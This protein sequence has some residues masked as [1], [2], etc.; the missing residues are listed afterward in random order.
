MTTK[1]KYELIDKTKVS[2]KVLEILE[3]ME[4]ASSNFTNAEVNSRVDTA[5]D[6]I[7]EGLKVSKPEALLSV[8]DAKKEVKKEKKEAE[9]KNKGKDLSKKKDTDDKTGLPKKDTVEERKDIIKKESE[10]E[11]EARERAKKEL[12]KENEKAKDAIESQIEK[13]NRIILEDPALRG[14]NTGTSATGGGKSTPLIDAERKAIA[15]GRRVSQKGR[16][17]QY[18]AS[19]GGRVYW[20]NRENRS[21]RK[22]PDYPT[23]KPYLEKGGYM[24]K[25]GSV[26]ESGYYAYPSG[27]EGNELGV[28]KD[29]ESMIS[30]ALANKDKYGKLIF[31]GI[32]NDDILEVNKRDSQDVV[33]WVFSR[34]G[35]DRKEA[36]KK[37]KMWF[38]SNYPADEEEAKQI[39]E[40]VTFDDI[41]FDLKNQRGIYDRLGNSYVVR[42][43]FEKIASIYGVEYD[44]VEK[45]YKRESYAKGGYMADGGKVDKRILEKVYESYDIYKD[46]TNREHYY[47]FDNI[48]K[49]KEHIEKRTGMEVL[50]IKEIE[51]GRNYPDNMSHPYYHDDYEFELVKGQ[52]LRVER[53]YGRPNYSGNVAYTNTIE[54]KNLWQMADGGRVNTI[55]LEREI[56]E[57]ENKYPKA[58]VSYS[59]AKDS[60]GKGYVIRAKEG[61]KIVYS[62]YKAKYGGMMADGGQIDEDTLQE[63]S[64][65][66]MDSIKPDNKLSLDEFLYAHRNGEKRFMTDEQEKL[67]VFVVKMYDNDENITED[68]LHELARLVMNS[69]NPNVNLSLDE[70][71]VEI[72]K[73]T[74]QDELCGFVLGMFPEYREYAKGGMMADGGYIESGE[75][76]Y[77]IANNMSDKEFQEAYRNL[78]EKEKDL[79]DTLLRLGDEGKIALVTVLNESKKPKYDKSTWDL[80]RYA[81]GGLVE[82]IKMFDKY[83]YPTPKTKGDKVRAIFEHFKKK[84]YST[85]QINTALSEINYAKGGEMANGGE[86]NKSGKV[87][88]YS[89][90]ELMEKFNI[91]RKQYL[92]YADWRAELISK[93]SKEGYQEKTNKRG[94]WTKKLAEGG[95]TESEPLG[96][97]ESVYFEVYDGNRNNG[98]I[99]FHKSG[100]RIF[101]T[102]LIG[103]VKAGNRR[104]MSYFT[105]NDLKSSLY[106]DFDVVNEVDEDY[107]QD[108]LISYEKSKPAD[109]LVVKY[110]YPE[111][112]KTADTLTI[113]KGGEQVFDYDPITKDF[114]LVSIGLSYPDQIELDD[115]LEDSKG[116]SES[117]YT[118]ELIK[119][120]EVIKENEDINEIVDGLKSKG[121]IKNYMMAE[122]GEVDFSERMAKMRSAY[123][124]LQMSVKGKIASAIGIDEA[125]AIMDT[126]YSIHPFNLIFG[127]VRGGLLELDEINK[128]LVNEAVDE[129]ERVTD[130]YRDSGQGIGGSDMTYFTQNVLN[131]AGYK[132]GFINNTLKRVDADGNELV[133]DKY[134]MKF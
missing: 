81:K 72:P 25:G 40:S 103:N 64:L 10:S 124:N 45:M 95:E 74:E 36:N 127:A 111:L 130:D 102:L 106:R 121:L 91:D 12:E 1:E 31:E 3:K 71:M 24:A 70:F 18:G 113:I 75:K 11:K 122:G 110:P 44:F 42:E 15:R 104:Y 97:N 47:D 17:N 53:M 21:D 14:F 51:I 56:K 79:Y 120:I 27:D 5:L 54:V 125:V 78:S 66:V 7:I 84:G 22:S 123:E 26:L 32:D 69:I 38:I 117:Q 80:H 57:T 46:G 52:P 49:V 59:F 118:P 20:E 13:L 30:F 100:S 19:A 132:T 63:L 99:K 93:A 6:K 37:I 105:K 77:E 39:D 126:D 114:S 50:K 48:E 83:N 62:S 82:E 61:S 60:T 9:E 33:T 112:A 76:L 73:T 96:I 92:T 34:I 133:I 35:M 134:E 8:S 109:I 28:F 90:A 88:T 43:V 55:E 89:D 131:S 23:G 128:D 29:K 65:L 98:I 108:R 115:F 129:A 116:V 94:I 68:E 101:E 4:K 119:V 85:E 87:K 58:K 86:M 16:K 41:W 67:V 107:V 2:A